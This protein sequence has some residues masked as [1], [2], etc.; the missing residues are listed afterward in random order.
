MIKHIVNLWTGVP[1]FQIKPPETWK[2]WTKGG[3]LALETSGGLLVLHVA[4]SQIQQNS[5]PD[6]SGPRPIKT[7]VALHSEFFQGWWRTSMCICF[8]VSVYTLHYI[9]WHYITLHVLYIYICIT[10][11]ACI[12][13]CEKLML[14]VVTYVYIYIH[15]YIY[16][17]IYMYIDICIYTCIYIYTYIYTH[18]YIYTYVCVSMCMCMR[19]WMCICICI[20]ICMHVCMQ[21]GR[22]IGM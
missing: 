9:T 19:M 11:V 15:M 14:F 3:F 5:P 10:H 4:T 21:V 18:S 8:C 12:E 17:Y 1:Y 22:S 20:C 16:V 7:A 2:F 13:R 6:L